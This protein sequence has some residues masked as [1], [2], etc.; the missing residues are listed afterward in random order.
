MRK[1]EKI[2]Q[3]ITTNNLKVKDMMLL[4]QKFSNQESKNLLFNRL[5]DFIKSEYEK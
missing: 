4:L 5:F 1:F 2:Y 3:I